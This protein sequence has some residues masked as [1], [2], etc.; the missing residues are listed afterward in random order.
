MHQVK[1][2]SER[3]YNIAKDRIG[4]T[5]PY[6]YPYQYQYQ[7]QYHTI[8]QSYNHSYIHTYI[9]TYLHTYQHT[10]IPYH[11]LPYITLQYITLH[12]ITYIHTN[13]NTYTH[14]HIHKHIHIHTHTHTIQ[15]NTKKK[16]IPYHTIPC[17]TI[18]YHYITI[19]YITIHTY[20]AKISYNVCIY[21]CLF[22]YYPYP[23]WGG[24]LKKV[25]LACSPNIDLTKCKL[26][27]LGKPPKNVLLLFYSCFL[28][29]I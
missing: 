4:A 17:H 15:Y 29:T 11:T 20:I 13:T 19:H 1:P 22:V 23:F 28:S 25:S 7:Y 18:P 8:I 2:K 6:P 27:L 5:Y 24:D 26:H 9:P 21:N 16:N 14:T 12:C 3:C 10:N